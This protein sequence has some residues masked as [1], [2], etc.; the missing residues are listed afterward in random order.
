MSFMNNH[1]RSW[2]ILCRNVRGVNS[3]DKCRAVRQAVDQS[4]CTVFCLQETKKEAFDT[5]YIKNW[6]L[7]G[8]I[9][10][11]SLPLWGFR[12]HSGLLGWGCFYSKHNMY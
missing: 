7:K 9:L 3:A 6:P 2:N 12:G 1:T 11:P 5:A 4:G 10:S 8:S